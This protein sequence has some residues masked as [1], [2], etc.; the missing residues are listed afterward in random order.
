MIVSSFTV[1]PFAENSYLLMEEESRLA[2][3]VDPGD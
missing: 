3:L 1:G 2:V